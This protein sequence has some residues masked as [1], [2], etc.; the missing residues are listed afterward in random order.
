MSITY[1]MSYPGPTW[2]IRGG[3]NFRSQS[4]EPTNPRRALKEWLSLCDAI[5]RASGHILVMPPP[6]VDPPLTGL[7]Y[8]ANAGQ[9]FKPGEQSTFLLSKM[10]VAHRQAER[11][12]VRAFAAEAGLHTQPADHPWEGQADLQTVGNT[13][14]FIATWGVR[15]VRASVDEIR[16]LLPPN[17]KLLDL[18][19]QEPFFHGDTCLSAIS[20]RAGDTLLLAHAGALV[21]TSIEALRGFVGN[22]IDVISVD[23]DDALAYACNSLAVNGTLLIP[24]GLSATLRGQIA[25]RGFVFEEIDLPELFG[26][27]GG[28]PRCLVNELRGVVLTASAPDYA[29]RRQELFDLVERYPERYEPPQAPPAPQ[30]PQTPPVPAA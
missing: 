23:R 6:T 22:R 8:T 27:G 18:Q 19:I 26:K 16:P 15:S 14:R 3:E 28:G 5:V 12:Y 1:L 4:R 9:L 21:G 20:N 2:H 24:P 30:T 11:E 13:N 7:I 17:A 25:R 10:A 29:S